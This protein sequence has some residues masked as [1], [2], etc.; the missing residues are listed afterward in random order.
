MTMAAVMGIL[1]FLGVPLV[2][3]GLNNTRGFFAHP[4]RVAY[5]VVVVLVIVVAL[6]LLPDGGRGRREGTKTVARQRI[7]VLLLQI[8]GVG[9][10]VVAPW[11]DGRG[12]GVLPL[13]DAA[14]YAG[15][16]LFAAGY[17]VVLWA[18]AV[19]GKQFSVQVTIQAG[20]K[21]ITSGPYRLVRHP[22]YTGIVMFL[23]GYGLMFLSWWA[24]CIVGGVAVVLAWRIHDE[25]GLLREQFGSQW[26]DYARRSRRVIPFMY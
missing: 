5:G 22:R 9:T 2:S 8:L 11:G 1:V 10:I 26:D 15:L 25:E 21:L 18:T 23:A 16:A 12:I 7:A 14:R 24:L 17:G 13:G 3:W 4:V 20:H 6:T 19:L